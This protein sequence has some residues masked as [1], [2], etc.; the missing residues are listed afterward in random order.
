M[1]RD[2]IL[3]VLGEELVNVL[4]ERGDQREGR[5]VV[6]I[7]RIH[8]HWAREL[9]RWVGSLRA[10]V[11]NLERKEQMQRTR[12]TAKNKKNIKKTRLASESRQ[13][14]K[15]LGLPSYL[16]MSLVSQ[17]QELDNLPKGIPEPPLGSLTWESHCHN[18]L[19][20]VGQVKVIALLLEPP[21]LL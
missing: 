8:G 1:H 10:Q 19:S 2:N 6:V 7:K 13:K 20:H 5:G 9:G 12:R 4:T 17:L 14:K 18:L 16:V 21:L 11:I 15:D 3:R